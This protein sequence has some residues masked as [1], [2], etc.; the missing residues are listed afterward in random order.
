MSAP[1]ML[2]QLANL[3]S[4][5]LTVFMASGAFTGLTEQAMR[6]ANDT[7]RGKMEMFNEALRFMAYSRRIAQRQK[8]LGK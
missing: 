8:N 7:D 5:E 2:T 6:D 4:E 3:S 1:D